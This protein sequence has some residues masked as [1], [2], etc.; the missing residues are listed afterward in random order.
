MEE[1]AAAV[2]PDAAADLIDK[3]RFGAGNRNARRIERETREAIVVG[4]GVES[5]AGRTVGL[6]TTVP[7]VTQV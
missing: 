6:P 1:H 5:G 3:D 4:A 2:M 7:G